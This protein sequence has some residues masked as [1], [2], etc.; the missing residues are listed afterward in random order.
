MNKVI[1]LLMVLALAIAPGYVFADGDGESCATP[2]TLAPGY[3]YQG[4]TQYDGNPIQAIGPIVSP[5]N[6]HIYAFTAIASDGFINMISANYDFAIYLLNAC[7]EPTAPVPIAAA[8]GNAQAVLAFSGL[9]VGQTYYLIV[10]APSDVN[11]NG[12]YELFM[13]IPS[14]SGNDGGLSC[15]SAQE[16]L[17]GRTYTG[18]TLNSS[19]FIDAIGPLSSLANDEVYRF[20]SDDVYG[21]LYI[22]AA[23]YDYGVFVT[24]ACQPD[25][26][27]PLAAVAGTAPTILDLSTLP[28]GG[29]YYLIVSGD[30]AAG[31]GANG[32]YS[33]STL[34]PPER[35]FDDGFD[36]RN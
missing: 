27:A 2:Q 34:P 5:A 36:G 25:T 24:S 15:A 17:P 16:L 20:S 28:A 19:N 3:G 22:D 8:A 9:T 26:P 31:A 21:F 13:P 30:P 6:D 12:Y 35:I 7:T 29:T 32:A 1:G 14:A 10:S 33:L 18:N 23:D 4:D 11:A